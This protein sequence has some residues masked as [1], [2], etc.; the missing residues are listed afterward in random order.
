ME[1]NM[2]TVILHEQGSFQDPPRN[3]LDLLLDDESKITLDIPW[4]PGYWRRVR[5]ALKAHDIDPS[6]FEKYP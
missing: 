6:Y 3:G 5:E 2:K 1:V 4:G